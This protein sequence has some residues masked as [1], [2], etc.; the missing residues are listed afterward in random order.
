MKVISLDPSLRSF[1][2]YANRDGIE[3][4]EVKENPG[5]S[6]PPGRSGKIAF[7]A[8]QAFGRTLGSVSDGR[9]CLFW[10]P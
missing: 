1:G 2:V 6:R 3:T 10:R 9:L 4:S 8:V 5:I 7:L